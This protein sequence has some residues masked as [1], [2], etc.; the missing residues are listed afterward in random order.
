MAKRSKKQEKR[1]KKMRTLILLL[2]L[3]II[4]LGTSTYAWFTANKVVTINALNVQVQ[5]AGGIQISTNAKDWKSVITKSD[6]TTGYSYNSGAVASVNQVPTEVTAVSSNCL[7]NSS[8]TDQGR[9]NMFSSV[10]TNNASTGKYDITTVKENDANG[11]TG[12]YIAF[13]VFLRLDSQSTVY[14]T[15]E[16]NVTKVGNEERGLKNAARV[17]FIQLGQG[18]SSTAYETMAAWNTPAGV[19]VW[20]PNYDAHTD[21]VINSVAPEYGVTLSQTNGVYDPVAYKGVSSVTGPQDLI[22]T[23]KGNPIQ[24]GTA[25]VTVNF[26]TKETNTEYITFYENMPAGV[27]KYRIYMWVEGQDIDCENNAT[28]SEISYKVVL[29]TSNNP[30]ETGGASGSSAAASS[31]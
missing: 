16:S 7:A 26:R 5:T 30:A 9:I 4:M 13:D 15:P 24:A 28:G 10:I 14:M 6:I 1:K 17:A 19:K 11:T 25:A 12:K 8:G 3:T 31:S 2:F 22:A 20:E 29:S 23:V 18:L 27:T 21:V